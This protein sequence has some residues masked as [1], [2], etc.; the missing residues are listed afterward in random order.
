MHPNRSVQWLRL[1]LAAALFAL[2]VAGQAEA[3]TVTWNLTGSDSLDGAE[4]NERS[5][6]AAGGEVLWARAFTTTNTDGTGLFLPAYLGRYSGGLGVTSP[7]DGTGASPTNTVDNIG[8]RDLVVFKFSG[9]YIPTSVFLTQLGDTDFTAYVG[10]NSGL[11]FSSFAG[12]SYSTLGANGFT[13]YTC[14]NADLLWQ[15]CIKDIVGGSTDRLAGLNN[16]GLNLSGQWLIIGALKGDATPEDQFLI[17]TL[18]GTAVPEPGTLLLLGVGLLATG[19]WSR[20]RF[21]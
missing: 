13:Q 2:A 10:G 12:L 5:F 17:K 4:G 6:P 11:T 14:G 9:A 21:F 15:S 7:G 19:L 20:K 16:L 18:N 1:G 8:T 3:V